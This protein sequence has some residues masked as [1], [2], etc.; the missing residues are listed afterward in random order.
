MIMD[1]GPVEPG[2]TEVIYNFLLVF[3]LKILMQNV[4]FT[5][6][7]EKKTSVVS[8]KRTKCLVVKVRKC[9]PGSFVSGYIDF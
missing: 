8:F 4:D 9:V 6:D 2:D 1:A 7:S 5:M 3:Y